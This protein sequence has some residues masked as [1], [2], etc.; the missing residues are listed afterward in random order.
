MILSTDGQLPLA[1]RIES[2]RSYLKD[3][4]MDISLWGGC[5]ASELLD[6]LAEAQA[7]AAAMRSALEQGRD[8]LRGTINYFWTDDAD[9]VLPHSKRQEPDDD[10]RAALKVVHAALADPTG[11]ALL[12][13][14]EAMEAALLSI[15]ENAEGAVHHHEHKNSGGQQCGYHGDFANLVPSN[16]RTL[17]EWARICRAALHAGAEEGGR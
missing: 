13:R 1:E 5:N 8:A 14:V 12:A 16:L 9:L 11:S 2:L 4:R 17:R 10:V 3:S 6:A 15:A 7:G